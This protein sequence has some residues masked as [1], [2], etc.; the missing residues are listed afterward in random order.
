MAAEA[1]TRERRAIIKA[2]IWQR[3]VV[4]LGGVQEAK[5]ALAAKDIYAVTDP[6]DNTKRLYIS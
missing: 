1:G 5:D 4:N 3:M 2:I 6:H